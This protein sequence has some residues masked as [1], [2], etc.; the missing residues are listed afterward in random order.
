[1]KQKFFR[2]IDKLLGPAIR[3]R[4]DAP[5]MEWSF[6]N[7]RRLGFDPRFIVDVG[8]FNGEWTAMALAEFPEANVLMLEA[9]ENKRPLMESLTI[10]GRGRVQHRIAVMGAKDGEKVVFHEYE[11]SPTASSMLT[12]YASTPTRNVEATLRT[13]DSILATDNFPQPD[14]IK[15]DVQGYELEVLKGSETALAGAEAVLMEVSIIEL[16]QESPVLHHVTAFMAERGFRAYDIC[17][18]LRRPLD[19]ALCQIDIIFVKETSRYFQQKT[20]N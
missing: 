10:N 14:L 11:H 9:Q 3:N 15:L 1:M 18:L 4:Y 6:R 20:W 5:S 16:Y 12:D 17:S 8:A 7:L 2:L 19:R 13:L